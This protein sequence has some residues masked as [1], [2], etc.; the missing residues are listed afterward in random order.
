MRFNG[1]IYS[2]KVMHKRYQ[3][4]IHQF[5]YSMAMMVIDLDQVEQLV[6]ISR[7]FSSKR[8]ALLRFKC[9]DYLNQ[10]THQFGDNVVLSNADNHCSA[11]ALKSRVL[12]TV[13]HLGGKTD[14]DKVLFAGQVRHFG[15]YF[16]PVNFYFCYHQGT[17]VYMLAEVSNTP[18]NER[19]CYLVNTQQPQSTDK[20]FPVSPFMD[21]QMQYKWQVTEPLEHLRVAIRNIDPQSQRL[22]DAKL[23]LRKQVYSKQSIQRFLIQF[24]FMTLSIVLGIYYQALKIWMKRIPFI[25]KSI[26]KDA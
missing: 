4:K 21:L 1:G 16:S 18:W 22:F 3:P 5:E 6:S 19:H 8:S 17:L 25:G 2:G 20:V 26:I 23:Q 11:A 9:S 10:L 7:I 13:A 24:P 12:K 15:L 14:I